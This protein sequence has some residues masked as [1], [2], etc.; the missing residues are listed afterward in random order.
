MREYQEKEYQGREYQEGG[1]GLF[2]G[3]LNKGLRE[4]FNEGTSILSVVILILILMFFL[5]WQNIQSLELEEKM[6][7]EEKEQIEL[8]QDYHAELILYEKL[9]RKVGDYARKELGMVFPGRGD[10]RLMKMKNKEKLFRV[11]GLERDDIE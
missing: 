11:L 2:W 6:M 1:F 3:G 8:Y 4:G 9:R 10:Y 5:I 7:R